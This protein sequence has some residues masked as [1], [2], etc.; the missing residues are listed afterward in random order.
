MNLTA[1]TS[2]CFLCGFHPDLDTPVSLVVPHE[3]SCASLRT[4]TAERGKE[5]G[6]W[7]H[8]LRFPAFNAYCEEAAVPQLTESKT[9]EN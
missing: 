3:P 7:K 1:S 2:S 6:N 8:T 5:T 9:R 4:G